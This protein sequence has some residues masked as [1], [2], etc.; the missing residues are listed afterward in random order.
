MTDPDAAGLNALVHAIATALAVTDAEVV[1][2][3]ETNEI[4]VRFVTDAAGKRLIEVTLGER[5]ARIG[6]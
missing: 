3:F 2:A 6:T 1:A 5:R 4:A